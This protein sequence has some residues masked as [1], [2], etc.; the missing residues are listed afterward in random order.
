MH[1]KW[2][3]ACYLQTVI[4]CQSIVNQDEFMPVLGY[5]V[6][7]MWC[8]YTTLKISILHANTLIIHFTFSVTVWIF[9]VFRKQE[10]QWNDPLCKK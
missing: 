6:N 4:E 1:L 10:A 3:R 8:F 5:R 9:I 2:Q 7:D